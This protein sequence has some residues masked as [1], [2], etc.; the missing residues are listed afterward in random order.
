MSRAKAETPIIIV[1]VLEGWLTALQA[2]EVL[3]ISRQSVARMMNEG[4]FKTLHAVGDRPLYVIHRDE[5]ERYLD[6]Y[7][8]LGSWSEAAEALKKEKFRF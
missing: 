4:T 6:L 2:A 7:D 3:G 5:V 1:P 8:E